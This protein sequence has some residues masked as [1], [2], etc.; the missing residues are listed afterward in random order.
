MAVAEERSLCEEPSPQRSVARESCYNAAPFGCF[1]ENSAVLVR[2]EESGK[3]GAIGLRQQLIERRGWMSAR[4]GSRLPGS[5]TPV[6]PEMRKLIEITAAIVVDHGEIRMRVSVGAP[7]DR[8]VNRADE[9]PDLPAAAQCPAA[10]RKQLRR[11]ALGSRRTEPKPR[12][13]A[14][15]LAGCE[16]CSNSSR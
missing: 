6:S 16:R 14:S 15:R 12:R 3:D 8:S 13:A 10:S 4:C 1:A 11:N 7:P 5:T 9:S 2:R